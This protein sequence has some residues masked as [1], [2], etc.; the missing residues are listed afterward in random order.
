MSIG[1]AEIMMGILCLILIVVVTA[2]AQPPNK[3]VEWMTKRSGDKQK[4]P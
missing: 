4:K 3:W 1:F 2:I